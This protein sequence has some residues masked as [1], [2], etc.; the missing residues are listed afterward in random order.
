MIR[1]SGYRFS[2]KIMLQRETR[3]RSR[4]FEAIALY[5]AIGPISERRDEKSP[6]PEVDALIF[7]T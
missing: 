2:D 6:A 5:S 7:D 3:A 1:K 4:Q